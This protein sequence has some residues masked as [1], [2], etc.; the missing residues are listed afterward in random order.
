MLDKY[1]KPYVL[2]EV[3]K[4]EISINPL[5]FARW[6]AVR[7]IYLEGISTGLATF[8]TA[9]PAWEL[10]DAGH[11]P[12]ARIVAEDAGDGTLLGWAALSPVSSRVV[13]AGV[14][15]VSVYVAAIARGTGVGRALLERL[16]EESE[17]NGIWT[18]QASIFEENAASMRLHDSC[19]FRTVGF[20]ERIAKL[21]GSWRDTMILERRSKVA[22]TD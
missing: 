5:K 17:R 20:R 22:G 21:N 7:T 1:V 18:L 11:L 15:E 14:A 6:K 4:L 10:W 3:L 19:G 16:I 13:Y 8:E 9:A 2:A 12:F